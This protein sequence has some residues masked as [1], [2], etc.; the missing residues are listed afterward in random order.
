[1]AG[2]QFISMR[3]VQLAFPTILVIAN[4][5]KFLTFL[6]MA[7]KL[8][9]ECEVLSVTRGRSAIETA[10]RVKPDLF[11][12]DYYL[13][14]LDALELSHRLHSMQELERVPTVLLNSPATSLK[15]PLSYHIIFLSMPFA[16][17]DFYAAVNRSLGRLDG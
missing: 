8:E 10:E 11:I 9:F 6:D 13:T 5:A 16:L 15:K 12:I 7:L 4:D 3:A 2:N 1:M 17:G 14:D